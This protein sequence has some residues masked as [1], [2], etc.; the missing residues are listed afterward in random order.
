MCSVSCKSD[1]FESRVRTSIKAATEEKCHTKRVP[2]RVLFIRMPRTQFLCYLQVLH[3][4]TRTTHPFPPT[5]KYQ[6]MHTYARAHT[7]TRQHVCAEGQKDS[8]F[9]TFNLSLWGTSYMNIQ[10]QTRRIQ[11]DGVTAQMKNKFLLFP[12][13]SSAC[14]YHTDRSV[15]FLA[16]TLEAN[17]KSLGWKMQ[18]QT[19]DLFRG[20]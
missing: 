10:S 16:A 6:C 4:Q 9:S 20:Y 1:A 3:L 5:K 13:I 11:R 19:C 15:T 7:Q 14:Y 8:L 2:K 12:T 18:Y 17:E